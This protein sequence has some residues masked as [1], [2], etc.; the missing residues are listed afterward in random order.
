MIAFVW[1]VAVILCPLL[2]GRPC[3]CSLCEKA[4]L[5]RLPDFDNLFVNEHLLWNDLMDGVAACVRRCFLDTRCRSVQVNRNSSRCSGHATAF[6]SPTKIYPP[7]AVSQ[8]SRLYLLPKAAH[9][10]GS[11]CTIDGDCH[12]ATSACNDGV[13][14][15]QIGLWFSPS[16]QACVT[17]CSTLGSGLVRYPGYAIWRN[18]VSEYTSLEETSCPQLCRDTCQSI[19]F[20]GERNRCIINTATY[21]RVSSTDQGQHPQWAYYQRN[22]AA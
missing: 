1:F 19:E 9:F 12:V 21:L 18:D 4:Q 14:T 10:I 13:C 22:C 20:D 7:A 11:A 2:Q 5:V 15:C 3:S 17:E 6:A 8:Y 16:Q